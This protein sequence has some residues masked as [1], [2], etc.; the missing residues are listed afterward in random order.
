MKIL[1]LPILLAAAAMAQRPNAG[2]SPRPQPEL[3]AA[4][5][6]IFPVTTG[7]R[8]DDH[9][10]VASGGGRVWV[11][12]VSFSETTQ[13]T[14]IH[15]RSMQGG[16]WSEPIVVSEAPGDYHKPAIAVDAAGAVWIAW[17]AQVRG[18][19]DIYGR[20]LRGTQ[21]S[22][23]ERWTSDA[24]ADLAPQL[25]ASKDG[26]LL[27]W[28]GVRKKNLDILYRYYKGAWGKEGFVT[29]NPANDWEPA[30]TVAHDGTFYVAWDSYRGDYDVFLRSMR[31]GVW[32]P[33][34]PVA[35]S[36]KLENHATL[37]VD[38]SDRLWIAWEVGPEKWAGDSHDSGLRP[39]RDIAIAC[40]KDG[41]IY[42]P[43]EAEA[44]L[45]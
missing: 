2:P 32:G 3:L 39:R 17:P 7:V 9:P 44:A 1:V 13:I 45:V 33:E 14:E 36:P 16:K 29:D 40:L 27:V 6:K 5:H 37:A 25:A 41:K 24:G 43:A 12:W 22:K 11:A 35:N 42:R 30:L 26:L 8:E 31:A 28:Q 15:A 20:V 10:A 18:N 4:L 19:W 23:T 38:N 34:T 21:W